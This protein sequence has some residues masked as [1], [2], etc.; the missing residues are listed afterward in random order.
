MRKI[1]P[2]LIH[3]QTSPPTSPIES[4]CRICPSPTGIFSGRE[5]ILLKMTLFF[6]PEASLR[7]PRIFVLTGLGGI[8]KTQ[9]A[10]R[11]VEEVQSRRH[12]PWYAL[13][14]RLVSAI[15]MGL[16]R[17][18]EV[19]F[20]DASSEKTI[21]A[22]FKKLA[23]LKRHGSTAEAGQQWLSVNKCHW[24][25]IFDNADDVEL[26]IRKFFP[27]GPHA[28]IIITSRNQET[29]LLSPKGHHDVPEMC[30]QD[31]DK[32]LANCLSLDNAE[33]LQACREL[34]S[35]LGCL[36][37]LL[38]QA[39]AYIE[40]TSCTVAQYL[41]ILQ[42]KYNTLPDMYTR[43]THRYDDYPHTAYAAW[44]TSFQKLDMRARMLLQISS[45][46]HHEEITMDLF[47]RASDA[48]NEWLGT[49]LLD[50]PLSSGLQLVLQFL[51]SFRSQ[52]VGWDEMLFLNI[53]HSIRRY[54]LLTNVKSG[55]SYSI[56][57]M[58][59]EWI[60]S[61]TGGNESPMRAA[62]QYLCGLAIPCQYPPSGIQLHR[63]IFTHLSVAMDGDVVIGA[64]LLARVADV[65]KNVGRYRQAEQLQHKCL[66]LRVTSLGMEHKDTLAALT[67]WGDLLTWNGHNQ[68]AETFGWNG[69]SLGCRLF[70]K[71]HPRTLDAM[72]LVASALHCSGR[73]FEAE[74]ILGE[75]VKFK[76]QVFGA[77]HPS[78]A[79]SI[80]ELAA[81]WFE[82]GWYEVAEHGSRNASEIQHKLLGID[83]PDRLRSLTTL[84]KSL[85]ELER[86]REA[87][88]VAK[89]C[90]ELRRI[91]LEHRH[92]ETIDSLNLRALAWLYLE[93]V[94]EAEVAFKE[95]LAFFNVF[96]ESR[97]SKAR[98]IDGLVNVSACCKF[99]RMEE[100]ESA[101]KD[102]LILAESFLGKEHKS[103]LNV[104]SHLGAL[105]FDTGRYRDAAEL[106]QETHEYQS[107]ILGE[108]HPN[109]STCAF[110]LQRTNDKLEEIESSIMANELCEGS[111]SVHTNPQLIRS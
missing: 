28:N 36:P 86:P 96:D 44:A 93:R 53:V 103:S 22:E 63:R 61:F 106:L 72:S 21:M 90:Y 25:L 105:Y 30:W 51:A 79:W 29:Q 92:P 64:G 42:K 55:G 73:Y 27:T 111:V 4:T 17:F 85:I 41:N 67:A 47:A 7:G 50:E 35:A 104:R 13:S 109:T 76:T 12:S 9:I 32:L 99:D 3:L 110:W 60:R 102:A 33:D 31:A 16:F 108:G 94:A 74:A 1:G 81:N 80:A 78:T 70:G 26:N 19:F 14:Q 75:V 34:A 91:V 15:F 66:Q 84:V 83:H 23:L 20:V 45:F 24:L 48:A 57:P 98:V 39:A 40:A 37:L 18:N 6:D 62:A 69:A 100:A 2:Q 38:V 89:E 59:H 46:L 54:S 88:E 11:F 49:S 68:E 8:G 56:H 97:Y 87:E 43:L 58:V 101:L 65:Y 10:C 5:E 95:Y 77:T 82:C 107:K 52:Q 71:R